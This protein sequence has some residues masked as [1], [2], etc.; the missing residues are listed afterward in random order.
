MT[1]PRGLMGLRER[2]DFPE[3]GSRID[4]GPMGCCFNSLHINWNA[5]WW[6]EWEMSVVSF[7]LEGDAYWSCMLHACM[8]DIASTTTISKLQLL[9][10][11][12]IHASHIAGT[13][14]PGRDVKLHSIINSRDYL[15]SLSLPMWPL[16]NYYL[17]FTNKNN[18]H[19]K[20]SDVV[21]VKL[22]H[23]TDPEWV[24]LR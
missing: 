24:T 5:W 20:I 9:L 6:A 15:T 3:E 14:R 8:L 23:V 17:Y 18:E 22:I 4:T 12:S 21:S 11:S 10:S 2:P 1:D 19:S 16:R 7:Q 13:A